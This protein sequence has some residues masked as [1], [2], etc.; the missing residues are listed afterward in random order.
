MLIGFKITNLNGQR[1]AAIEFIRSVCLLIDP[2]TAEKLVDGYEKYNI[3]SDNLTELLLAEQPFDTV[4]IFTTAD[5]TCINNT[6]FKLELGYVDH[7]KKAQTLQLLPTEYANITIAM[8]R[9]FEEY[10]KNKY[11]RVVPEFPPGWVGDFTV[12][13][14]EPADFYTS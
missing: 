14:F 13:D 1:E 7:N 8:M 2:T 11:I 3:F 5:I 12:K 9:Q 10:I 4:P 6:D